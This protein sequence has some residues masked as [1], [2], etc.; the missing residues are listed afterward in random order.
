VIFFSHT[1]SN[2]FGLFINL[3]F[4]SLG[5]L[6]NIGLITG[7]I[8]AESAPI[9]LVAT[10]IGLV[11]GAGEIFGGG[12]APLIGGYIAKNFGIQNILYLALSGVILGDVCSLFL[13]ET[14]PAVVAGIKE[15][16]RAPG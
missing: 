2:S 1:G 6:G 16:N 3:F 12:V 7:P 5:C 9:G 15:V 10:A 13:R 4:I 14:A 8:A 11:V